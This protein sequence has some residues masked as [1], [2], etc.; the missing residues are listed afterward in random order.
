MSKIKDIIPK[1]TFELI[2]D[3]LG[4][5]LLDELLHQADLDPTIIVNVFIERSIPFSE[6]E[7]PAINISLAR[8]V[9]NSKSAPTS[10]VGY[11]YFVDC[12]TSSPSDQ[13]NEGDV[14][15][16]ISLHRYIGL[17]KAIF[18]NPVYRTLGF[19]NPFIQSFTFNEFNI[20]DPGALR[21]QDAANTA[22]GR[23]S[24][25]VKAID[26]SELIIPTIASGY[27]T[28]IKFGTTETGYA[29]TSNAL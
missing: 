29:Y 18:E 16:A 19:Q 11:T 22:M 23:L 14:L 17:C 8:G 9:Y 21:L 1:Q 15:S 26:K 10:D 28:Q 25:L 20:A 27:D 2:R 24:F 13:N 5:I 4:D 12:Y 3:R 6:S 7:L